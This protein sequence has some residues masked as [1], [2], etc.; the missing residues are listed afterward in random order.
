[1]DVHGYSN[2]TRAHARGLCNAPQ[3]PRA[4][5]AR[6]LLQLHAARLAMPAPVPLCHGAALRCT[7][8]PTNHVKKN[9]Q[10]KQPAMIE[11]GVYAGG[12]LSLPSPSAAAAGLPLSPYLSAR[13]ERRLRASRMRFLSA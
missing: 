8:L 11:R 7:P 13:M 12:A 1:M 4:H 6:S 9:T 5:G 3:S 2:G 10:I